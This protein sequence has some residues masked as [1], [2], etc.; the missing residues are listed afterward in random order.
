MSV[1]NMFR[2]EALKQQYKSQEFGQAVV[3]H[4][5]LISRGILALVIFLAILAIAI[6][7]LPVYTSKAYALRPHEANFSPVVFPHAAVVE[8]HFVVDGA[9]VTP[10]TLISQL[11]FFPRE[12]EEQKHQSL[13][14]MSTGTFFSISV[15]GTVVDALQPIAKVLHHPK[16]DQFHFWL[17]DNKPM[18]INRKQSVTLVSG[19]ETVTGQIVALYNSADERIKVTIQ[20]THPYNKSVLNPNAPLHLILKHKRRNILQLIRGA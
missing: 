5:I 15:E 9:E 20:L 4:P 11:R 7:A 1:V 17:E 14:S 12:Q 2:K 18:Q 6:Q 16:S 10:N 8:K 19:G 3:E 13:Y